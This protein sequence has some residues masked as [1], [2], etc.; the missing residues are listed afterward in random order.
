MALRTRTE[1]C[2][3]WKGYFALRK[4]HCAHI[5]GIAHTE[6]AIVHPEQAI[7]HSQQNI[8]QT[9]KAIVHK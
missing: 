4:E 2:Q 5:T 6:Q 7:M 1:Y 8:A 3:H 9:E